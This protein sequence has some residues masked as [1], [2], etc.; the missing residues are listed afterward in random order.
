MYRH[1]KYTIKKEV[2]GL[3]MLIYVDIYV[4]FYFFALM[5]S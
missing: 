1:T 4:F 2:S 3:N 5:Y